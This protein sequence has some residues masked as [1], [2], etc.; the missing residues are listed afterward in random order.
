[1]TANQIRLKF[2]VD[3]LFFPQK[4]RNGKTLKQLRGTASLLEARG[5]YVLFRPHSSLYLPSLLEPSSYVTG[6]DKTRLRRTE[7][8]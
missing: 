7:L 4:I 2:L 8:H 1:M 5:T 3:Y 6:F